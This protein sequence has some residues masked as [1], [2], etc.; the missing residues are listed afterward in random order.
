M[1]RLK[2]YYESVYDGLR[3]D[4]TI[5]YG[6]SLEDLVFHCVIHALTSI[7]HFRA[8]NVWSAQL[9]ATYKLGYKAVSIKPV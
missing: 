4:I 6:S 5:A 1:V 8:A 9:A 2:R 3:D 7:L